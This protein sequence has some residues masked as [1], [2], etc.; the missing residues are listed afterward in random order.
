MQCVS[1]SAAPA[2]GDLQ[3]DQRC[4]LAPGLAAD[5]GARLLRSWCGICGRFLPLICVTAITPFSCARRRQCSP[6]VLTRSDRAFRAAFG[7]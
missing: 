2:G 7:H 1:A 3:D 6:L 5:L 4:I